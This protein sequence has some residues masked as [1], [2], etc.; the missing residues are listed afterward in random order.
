MDNSGKGQFYIGAFD[1]KFHLY[2]AEW[3]AWT[4]D[5]EARYHGGAAAPTPRPS[6]DKVE[7]VVKYTDTDNNGYLDTIEYDYNGDGVVDFKVCLL[8][9]KTPNNPHPDVV[10]LIPTPKEGWKGL[11]ETF[12]AT[13]QRSWIEAQ[14]VYRAAWR[15]GLTTPELDLLMQAS[16]LSQRYQQAYW[17][18]EKV[19]RLL[20]ARLAE[21]K[22]TTRDALEK[23]LARAYYTGRF[24][25]YIQLIGQVPGK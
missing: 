20:R 21:V 11:H 16:S 19:F 13:A 24:D 9:Y 7:E 15:R 12:N 25:D 4:V 10:P 17:I 8:D 3:G 2:G 22:A 23:D 5:S 1:R 14:Q 6:A 18:K